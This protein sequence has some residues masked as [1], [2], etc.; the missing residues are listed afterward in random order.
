VQCQVD[1]GLY[2]RGRWGITGGYQ[3]DLGI[4]EDILH[5]RDGK[6][7]GLLHQVVVILAGNENL[8]T[9]C[10]QISDCAIVDA[11][12]CTQMQQAEECAGIEWVTR[13]QGGGH[14]ARLEVCEKLRGDGAV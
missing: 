4:A 2:L 6:L 5:E 10:F 7:S 9:G 14:V 8:C 1:L 3:L 11:E 12:C 13:C